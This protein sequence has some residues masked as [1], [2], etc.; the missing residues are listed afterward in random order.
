[1]VVRLT[2]ILRTL[3]EIKPE[4]EKTYHVSSIGVFGSAVR[5]D[6][7]PDSDID[8][9]VDFSEPVGVSFIDLADFLEQKIKTK[10]DL[11]SR[12]GVKPQYLTAI[13]NDIVYV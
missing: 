11:V 4:L 8:I 13:E 1:M 2:A 7:R 6:F 5:D 3:Q 12:K 9:L 10:V